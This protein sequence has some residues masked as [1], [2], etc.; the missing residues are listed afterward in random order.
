MLESLLIW[1]KHCCQKETVLLAS[2]TCNTKSKTLKVI[3]SS[4]NWF[5]FLLDLNMFNGVTSLTTL[6]F[7]SSCR[8]D[9]STTEQAGE[10]DSII[11]TCP[12]IPGGVHSSPNITRDIFNVTLR[13]ERRL[14]VIY[15]QIAGVKSLWKVCVWAGRVCGDV[16]GDASSVCRAADLDLL[17]ASAR[18]GRDLRPPTS[19]LKA[20]GRGRR[21]Y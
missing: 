3:E 16:C 17:P 18:R 9:F 5:Q 12:E 7:F 1:S 11:L 13:L 19:I 4:L 15:R 8:N 21:A 10:V 20:P 14:L 2:N 6:S